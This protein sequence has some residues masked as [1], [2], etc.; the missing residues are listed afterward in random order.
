MKLYKSIF[1][2]I[3][4][5]L[6]VAGTTSCND[7]DYDK[8]LNSVEIDGKILIKNTA[9]QSFSTRINGD[10][11]TVLVNPL[12]DA[13]SV[14]KHAYPVFYLPMGATCAPDP[15]EMQDFTKEVKYTITSGNGKRQRTYTFS[16]Y[17]SS[18]FVP[19]GE[20]FTTAQLLAEKVVS[21]LGYPMD[22]LAASQTETSPNGGLIYWP[23]YCGKK[24]V[25]FS[26]SYAWGIDNGVSI[27]PN[28]SL[29]IKIFDPETLIEDKTATLNLGS[30]TVDKI[31]NI[32]NDVKGHLIA[33]TGGENGAQSDVY[34]WTAID[35]TPIHLG[36]LP[37]PV[38]TNSHNADCSKFIQVAGDITTKAL[39]SYSP[40]FTATGDHIVVPVNGGVMDTDYTT[41]S[42]Y[43]DVM[44]SGYFQ[45]IAFY[46]ADLIT[47]SYAVGYNEGGIPKVGYCRATG[48][49]LYTSTINL[50][51]VPFTAVAGGAD[52]WWAGDGKSHGKGGARR[53]FVSAM[54]INGKQ[55]MLALSGYDW[56]Q[57]AK[58][59]SADFKEFDTESILN[60]D[61][62]RAELAFDS[63]TTGGGAM[64][65]G[66]GGCACWTYDEETREANLAIWYSLEGLAT[67]RLTCY[68]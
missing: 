29:A 15:A 66:Y 44:V 17:G 53:P 68:E 25:G 12:L 33:C 16:G 49:E 38:Y 54:T 42:T 5:A 47:G 46:D 32:C 62:I 27:A 64:A 22:G 50:N 39:I 51:A 34:Y 2:T 48:G 20:G 24:L 67:F 19:E 7:Y 65:Y 28:P 1:M 59:T 8:E 6:A 30:L 4:G 58:F 18:D 21:E 10:D 52:K 26:R 41:I 37:E 31:V 11:I 45:M 3:V 40:K 35:A 13:D 9:G 55:Y 36:T 60:H 43:H 14:L 23:A 56:R 63:T 61:F 57:K